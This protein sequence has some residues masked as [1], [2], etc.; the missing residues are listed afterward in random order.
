MGCGSST[1][2]VANENNVDSAPAT[3]VKSP[4]KLFTPM[5]KKKKKIAPSKFFH[6]DLEQLASCLFPFH[7]IC[8][9]SLSLLEGVQLPAPPAHMLTSVL[10]ET[11]A[12]QRHVTSIPASAYQLQ[13]LDSL[14]LSLQGP[15]PGG[16]GEPAGSAESPEAA[17]VAHQGLVALLH[18][19][20]LLPSNA[21]AH[22]GEVL[23][24]LAQGLS[25]D[26]LRPFEPVTPGNALTFVRIS[27]QYS[28]SISPAGSGLIEAGEVFMVLEE[29]HS[30]VLD[31]LSSAPLQGHGPRK[32]L[33]DLCAAASLSAWSS[34]ALLPRVCCTQEGSSSVTLLPSQAKSSRSPRLWPEPGDKLVMM[35]FVSTQ[36]PF[37]TVILD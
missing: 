22:V 20:G 2:S 4:L 8:S 1:T 30:P 31:V 19:L 5:K 24:S 9:P 10:P 14:I 32:E 15:P 27:P 28:L 7:D 3:L 35:G 33:F 11:S 17:V 37:E 6:P 12:D 34:P 21:P 36:R 29:A 18:W 13:G 23:E 25:S 26:G 16:I